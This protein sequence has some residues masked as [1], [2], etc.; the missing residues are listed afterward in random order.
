ML[1][2]LLEL[3]EA[4]D[5]APGDPDTIARELVALCRALDVAYLP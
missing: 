5:R 2:A 4:R 3:L 1:E